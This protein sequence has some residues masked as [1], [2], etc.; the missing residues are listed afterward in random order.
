MEADHPGTTPTTL[1]GLVVFLGVFGWMMFVFSM[2]ESPQQIVRFNHEGKLMHC[3]AW[4][5][6]DRN[7]LDHLIGKRLRD[8]DQLSFS[9]SQLYQEA[10][11]DMP[12]RV[13]RRIGFTPV[14]IEQES[15]VPRCARLTIP[16]DVRRACLDP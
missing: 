12:T 2:E 15:R 7:L 5:Q 8:P 4:Y 1:G 13:E 6:R 11:A 14:T 10:P 3:S 16:G 9:C